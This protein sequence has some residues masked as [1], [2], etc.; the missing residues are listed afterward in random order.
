ME[1]PST[2]I[3]NELLK[4]GGWVKNKTLYETFGKEQGYMYSMC[5]FL[6]STGMI[7]QK[8]DRFFDPNIKGLIRKVCYYRI[9]PSQKQRAIKLVKKNMF[10]KELL[11]K[12]GDE[13]DGTEL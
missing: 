10:I 2:L 12:Y 7:E 5:R 11:E 8:I 9:K 3:I 4:R 1:K 6:K 13:Y